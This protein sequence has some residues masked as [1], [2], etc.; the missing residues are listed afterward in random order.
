MA[1]H[2]N[3]SR[4]SSG[5]RVEGAPLLWELRRQ[6]YDKDTPFCRCSPQDQ[7]KEAATAAWTQCRTWGDC[8]RDFA[9]KLQQRKVVLSLAFFNC[10]YVIS[11]HTW[12]VRCSGKVMQWCFK[13]EAMSLS[14][15]ASI[16][17]VLFPG[18][19]VQ[20]CGSNMIQSIPETRM[21]RHW[22]DIGETREWSFHA[23]SWFGHD[24]WM[25]HDTTYYII[26]SYIIT[27][28]FESDMLSKFTGW[29]H[30]AICILWLCF[31]VSFLHGE[32]FKRHAPGSS[33]PALFQDIFKI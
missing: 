27:I 26:L 4:G 33:C 6:R 5:D 28:W 1:W 19:T 9:E 23:W 18:R 20:F 22:R 13:P 3:G 7:E 17:F 10:D 12:L 31:Q 24:S 16:G 14:L 2:S 8:G 21:E 32:H 30:F 25:F 29:P 15:L 11:F